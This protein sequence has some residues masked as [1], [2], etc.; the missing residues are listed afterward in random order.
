MS[1]PKILE[2]DL[3]LKFGTWWPRIRPFWA[4]GGFDP[5]YRHLKAEA[6]KGVKIAPA[7]INTYRAFKETPFEE[8]KAV[9]MCQDPYAKFINDQPIA[10]GVAMDCSI[11]ARVQPT[12][13]NFY[14]GIET[15]LYNGLN[16]DYINTYDL[17]YL[18]KQ[19]VLLLNVALTVE[20]D[21]P[22][23][24][25]A[26]WAPFMGFLFQ[27]VIASTGVPVLLLGREAATLKPLIEKT[28]HVYTLPHPASAAYTGGKWDTKGTFMKIN[29]NIY[30]S[31]KDTILWLNID[32]P[33]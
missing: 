3:A 24:H 21:R 27:E 1:E 14:N 6:K 31:N 16:L 33:F 5:I 4:K 26:T 22:G 23:S 20:K 28:N 8:L 17:S 19:G 2:K 29:D 10:S 15:E 32:A 11:T 13:Q 7:S 25:I 30:D 12:L 9:V 18:S